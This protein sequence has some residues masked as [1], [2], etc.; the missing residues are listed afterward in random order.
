MREKNVV[1]ELRNKFSDK[2]IENYNDNI[3]DLKIQSIYLSV[4]NYISIVLI[5]INIILEWTNNFHEEWLH[6]VFFVAILMCMLSLLYSQII[7]ERIKVYNMKIVD[8]YA[9]KR[10]MN[11]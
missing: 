7:N 1:K 4:I 2:Q 11:S 3:K 5:T 6:T 9:E 10:M 8:L